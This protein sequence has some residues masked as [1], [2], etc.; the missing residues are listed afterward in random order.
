MFDCS[1]PWS[2]KSAYASSFRFTPVLCPY[3]PRK[4]DAR[5]GAHNGWFKRNVGTV[6]PWSASAALIRGMLL[7]S[8]RSASSTMISTIFGGVMFHSCPASLLCSAHEYAP[9][10]QL[11][12]GHEEQT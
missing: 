12:V 3:W 10:S 6:A 8:F 4:R 11:R 1:P 5:D 9:R 7:N 2:M